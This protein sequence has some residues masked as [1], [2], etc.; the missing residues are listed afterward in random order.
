MSWTNEIGRIGKDMVADFLK[1]RGYI[2]FKRNF[3]SKYGE[4]DIVAENP[5]T[6]I[7]V[8]VKTREQGS[9][10]DPAFAVDKFKQDKIIKTAKRFLHLAHYTGEYRF[11]VAEVFYNR[12]QSG[13]LKFSLNYIKNAF[14]GNLLND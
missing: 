2:I 6:V 13:Q 5:Q 8:E 9:L 12:D 1:A 4:I 14:E 3:R 7:F 10:V 11:D